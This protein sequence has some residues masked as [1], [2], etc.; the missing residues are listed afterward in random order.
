M[1]RNYS[2]NKRHTGNT[3]AMMS[4]NANGS[5]VIMPA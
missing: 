2:G 3:N 1:E 5:Y 4:F